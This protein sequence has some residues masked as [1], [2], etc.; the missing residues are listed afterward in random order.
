MKKALPWLVIGVVV[1]MIAKTAATPAQLHNMTGMYSVD[2]HEAIQAVL[3]L[4]K[5][6]AGAITS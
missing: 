1:L 2:L 6:I 3:G 5:A 4:V